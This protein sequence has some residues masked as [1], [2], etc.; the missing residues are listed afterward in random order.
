MHCPPLGLAFADQVFGQVPARRERERPDQKEGV[1]ERHAAARLR[2]L[3][4]AGI[5]HGGMLLRSTHDRT[6]VRGTLRSAETF[7]APPSC[8]MMVCASI[9]EPYAMR[10][11]CAR[12]ILPSDVT[13]RGIALTGGSAI[14]SAMFDSREF[15]DRVLVKAGGVK[16]EIAR[17]LGIPAPRVSEFFKAPKGRK[18][19]RRLTLDE[20]MALSR[21]FNV[22]IDERIS[23][24]RLLT[25]LRVVLRH[26][27]K[28]ELGEPDL[29]RLAQEISSGLEL[30]QALGTGQPNPEA[31]GAASS[32]SGGQPPKPRG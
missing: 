24:E 18:Q 6:V 20:G 3:S 12:G 23:A 17:A 4:T 26:T 16:A 13:Q 9:T 7:R 28:R 11:G 22:P 25:V 30:L 2:S 21:A 32:A 1:P 27:P 8:S 15:L 10:Y 19:P 31:P 5:R 14:P 29:E